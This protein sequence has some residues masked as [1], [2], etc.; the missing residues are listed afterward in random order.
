MSAI[1]QLSTDGLIDFPKSNK[2]SQKTTKQIPMPVVIPAKS[3]A[4]WHDRAIT[5]LN[6]IDKQL[7]KVPNLP[8][9]NKLDAIGHAI[10]KKFQPLSKFNDWINAST[11]G[12]WYKQLAMFLVKL[13]IRAVR[14]IISMLY[15]I[16]KEALFLAVHPLKGLNHLV[17]LLVNL[18]HEL[19]KPA[20]WS[21]IGAG[22]IG[23]SAGQALVTGNPLSV[24][25]LGIGGA[26]LIGGLSYRAVEAA[27]NAGRGKRLSAAAKVLS[28]DIKGLPEPAMTG[29]VM[30]LLMGAIQKNYQKSSVLKVNN[31]DSARLWG[32]EYIRTHN[33]PAA[34]EIWYS[35]RTNEVCLGW[36]SSATIRHIL[37]HNSWMG[38]H[39]DK[40]IPYIMLTPE[41]PVKV[42]SVAAAPAAPLLGGFVKA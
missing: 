23:A 42:L 7:D 21:K 40:G 19:S 36:K 8:I 27:A 18:V 41:M 4:G 25:G 13:P 9:Q 31:N 34:D 38:F 5:Y 17:K 2:P 3:H 12:N 24:I 1:N 32:N 26:L 39:Y 11:K 30:G 22:I 15:N 14:N 37:K 35:A 20:V 33:L 16:I 10:E 29:F 6:T 28:A